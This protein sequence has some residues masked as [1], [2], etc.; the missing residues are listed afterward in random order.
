LEDA[1]GNGD[2]DSNTETKWTS[3]GSGDPTDSDGDGVSDYVEVLLGRNPLV[4]GAE[5]DGAAVVNL[6]RYTPLK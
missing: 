3:C 6:N 2:C 1:N 4:R 5:P